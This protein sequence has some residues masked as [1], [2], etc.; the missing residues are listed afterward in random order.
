MTWLI[1]LL[2]RGKWLVV[3]K[4]VGHLGHRFTMVFPAISVLAKP[5]LIQKKKPAFQPSS[6]FRPKLVLISNISWI[7]QPTALRYGIWWSEFHARSDSNALTHPDVLLHDFYA[8]A[9]CGI[10]QAKFWPLHTT[11]PFLHQFLRYSPSIIAS[12][13]INKH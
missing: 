10:T 1:S 3:T 13:D 4:K 5:L 11:V 12:I 7:K 6:F 2:S 8:T 9:L